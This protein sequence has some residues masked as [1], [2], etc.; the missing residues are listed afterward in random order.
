M[1][2]S[3]SVLARRTSSERVL[4]AGWRTSS[5][6]VCELTRPHATPGS[7]RRAHRMA[8]S[9]LDGAVAGARRIGQLPE[10]GEEQPTPWIHS[11][12]L[13]LVVSQGLGASPH[14][15]RNRLMRFDVSDSA[16]ASAA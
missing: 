11:D 10:G 15:I 16:S 9:G 12:V 1:L 3:E 8:P 6:D 7:E 5:G 2:S 13:A 4:P 14:E